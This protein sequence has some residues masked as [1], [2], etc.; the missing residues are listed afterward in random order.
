MKTP[1]F[2]GSRKFGFISLFLAFLGLGGCDVLEDIGIIK[3]MY[4]S[5]YATFSVKGTVTDE[6]G[7][8]IQ[9]LDV[10][11]HGVISNDEGQ[12]MAVPSSHSPVKTDQKGTYLINIGGIPYSM[13]QVNVNDV[14]G[15]ANGGEFASDS[16]RISNYSFIKDKKDK[17]EWSVGTADITVPDIKLKKK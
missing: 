17:N 10:S 14:D 4:G 6:Q 11:L 15:T 12:T 8:P 9:D 13:I 16:L 7:N 1:V 2:R 5:P 3:C